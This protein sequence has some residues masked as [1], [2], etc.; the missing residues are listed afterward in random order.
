MRFVF[1][2]KKVFPAPL[3]QQRRVVGKEGW[4]EEEENMQNISPPFEMA[5][6][7][8]SPQ[9]KGLTLQL[10]RAISPSHSSH[11]EA[12][13]QSHIHQLDV[14]RP[15]ANEFRFSALQHQRG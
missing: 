14:T 4:G 6:Y 9:G 10:L 11:C 3:L 12:Q 2:Q 15:L 1:T 8:A 5:A 7:A 13:L